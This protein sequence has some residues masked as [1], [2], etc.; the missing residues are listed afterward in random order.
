MAHAL[1]YVPVTL[2]EYLAGEQDGVM[3]HEFVDGQTYAMTGVSET[4]NTIAASFFLAI[5]G[6]LSDDCRGWQS[7][8]KLKVEKSGTSFVYYPDIMVACGENIDD[9]YVRTNPILIIEVLS[10]NTQRVDL[11][12]K[13]DNY[14]TIPSLIEYVVV[15]QDVPLVRLFRRR[16]AWRMED[17]YAEDVVCLESVGINVAVKEVYRKVKKEV[18]LLAD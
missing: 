9:P 3:R 11:K 15:S 12:E 13:F 16:N 8:M 17:H 7:D 4:H 1:Q 2:E 10:P 18:G 6:K 5:G 14:I